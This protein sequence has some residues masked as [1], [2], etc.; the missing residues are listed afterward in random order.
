MNRRKFL[1]AVGTLPLTGTLNGVAW[2]A[3]MP[4]NSPYNKLL[5]L[6]ELK[7]DKTP[8][9]IVAQSL[10]YASWVEDL[11]ADKIALIYERFSNGGNFDQAFKIHFG[12]ELDEESL[13][14]SHQIIIVAAELDASTERI[15][16]YLNARDIAIN[17]IFFQVFQQGTDQLL[18][19]AWLIDPGE[20]QAN[21]ATAATGKGEK[22]PWNGAF[23]AAHGR[24]AKS[25][26][27]QLGWLNFP[28]NFQKLSG[29]RIHSF[30]SLCLSL[31][32]RS[33]VN[34]PGPQGVGFDELAPRL[35]L[36]AHQ[37][38]EHAVGFDGVVYL[39]PQQAAH[40]RVHGGLPQLH[41]VHLAQAFVALA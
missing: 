6:I 33:N 23:M 1:S 8:R 32:R 29:S 15:I 5:V 11:T 36:V 21:V 25:G 9:E 28:L 31:Q 4:V 19:R 35:D 24:T 39:H 14:Q 27:P 20:T 18:S 2:A 38:G 41:R 12:A 17:A 16:G 7:R 13:N 10:D 34:I 3:S 26:I 22:E 40:G 37:H 30:L